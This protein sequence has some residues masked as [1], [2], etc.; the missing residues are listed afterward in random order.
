MKFLD[1]VFAFLFAFG[2]ALLVSAFFLAPSAGSE[3]TIYQKAAGQV[4]KVLSPL[5]QG[6]GTGFAIRGKSGKLIVLTNAH[7][8]ALAHEGKIIIEQGNGRKTLTVADVS[9]TT[10]L[11]ALTGLKGYEGLSLAKDASLLDPTFVVGHPRLLP[12]QIRAGYITARETVSINYCQVFRKSIQTLDDGSTDYSTCVK[13]IDSYLI[14]NRIAPGNSGS[15]ALDVWGNV[16]GVVYAGDQ[17]GN[18]GLAVPL[19]VVREYLN[20]F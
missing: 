14:S 6:G 5:G 8:C 10:D 18:A 16:I 2:V 12:I 17:W 20:F 15:P 1:K 19:N 3:T 4:F 9:D 7:V 13:T 11:C